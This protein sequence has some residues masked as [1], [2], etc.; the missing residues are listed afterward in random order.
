MLGGMGG[1]VA[2]L[3]CM[4]GHSIR[5]PTDGDVRLERLSCVLGGGLGMFLFR[6]HDSRLRSPASA[7]SSSLPPRRPRSKGDH[8]VPFDLCVSASI[9]HCMPINPSWPKR[10]YPARCL[11]AGGEIGDETLDAKAASP[12]RYPHIPRRIRC[13]QAQVG[14]SLRSLEAGGEML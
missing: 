14:L 13:R 9:S 4:L 12:A 8:A 1:C 11:C 6:R 2:Q 10:L 7:L 5:S 3:C